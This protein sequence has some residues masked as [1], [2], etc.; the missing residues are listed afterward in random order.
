[1]SSSNNVPTG[2]CVGGS[3]TTLPVLKDLLSNFVT[4]WAV[5]DPIGSVRI[6][7][8]VTS[9]MPRARM[10]K[11]ANQAVL[12]AGGVL[13]AFLV[14]GQIILNAMGISIDAFRVAGG[15]ILF[16]FAIGMIFHEPKAEKAS[17]A[18]KHSV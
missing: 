14:V 5:I 16:R 4:L 18:D 7:L 6:F 2:I 8:A 17:K 11:V 13:I 15:I 3:F 9:H 10:T 12:V 1:M